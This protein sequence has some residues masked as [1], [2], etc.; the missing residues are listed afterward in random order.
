MKINPK[1]IIIAANKVSK[2][3]FV[4]DLD[5]LTKISN[6]GNSQ[7]FHVS[8]E[9]ALRPF[10]ED[11]SSTDLLYPQGAGWYYSKNGADETHK[12]DSQLGAICE[13]LSWDT[14][15]FRCFNEEE[16]KKISKIGIAGHLG[17]EATNLLRDA[18][19]SRL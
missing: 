8:E 6:S 3:A 16:A 14:H 17:I 9:E 4:G 15:F 13:V 18:I 5:E 2:N 12:A 1:Y 19:E 10:D 7:C 11:D